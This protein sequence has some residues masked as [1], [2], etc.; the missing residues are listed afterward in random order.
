MSGTQ[1]RSIALIGPAGAGKTSLAEALLHIS[2]A[3]TRQ[4]SVEAGTSVGDASPEARERGSSTEINFMQFEWMGDPFSLIDIPGSPSFADDAAIALNAADLAI[5][6]ID[7]DP[8]RAPLAEP[9]LRKLERAGVPHALFVNKIEQARGSI[10]ELL[11]ALSPMSAAA[12]VAR[13]IPIRSGDRV[14]GFVDLALERAYHY[15]A[16]KPSQQ[17]ALTEELKAD[18]SDARFHM[19]EQLADHDDI[20]LEQLLSDEQPSL[21]TIFADLAQETAS[22][23]IVPV[24]FGSAANGFGIRRLLKMLRHD[25]PSPE[26]TAE[27]LGIDGA[28]AQVLKISHAA[29]VGRL[30]IA[31]L[32]GGK[33]TDGAE[34]QDS[35]GQTLRAGGLFALQG[36]ATAKIASA[37]PGAVLGIAKVDTA[38][39]GDLIGISARPGGS[40]LQADRPAT[41]CAIAIAAKDHKDEVRLSTALNRLAEEDHALHWT[42]DE[43]SRETLL[44]GVSD[45][46]LNVVLARLRRRYGVAVTAQP[47]TIAYRES[48]RK[49][50]TQRGRHKKQSGGHGQF[51]DVVLEVRPLER[52]EGIR[53]EERITGGAIPKQW[54]PAVEKGVQD[55]IAKG[56]LGFPVVDVAAI[57]VDGSFHSVDSSELAFRTAGRIAMSEALAAASPY[58]LEPI[59]HVT[60]MTPGSA[61]SRITSAIA[62]RRGQ[63]LR[64][65]SREGWSAWDVIEVLLPEAGLQGLEAE[66]RSMSQGMASFETHFD[67]LAEV[68]PK[69]ASS[70]VQRVKE[71]A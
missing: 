36:S 64:M 7:P 54:I 14:D 55:A 16:G 28:A 22:G 41:N 46:H 18:E 20:L 32:F 15:E 43:A 27:R 31:R 37:D 12:L 25:T 70:I 21:Q 67:H 30:A 47:P 13:Q 59:A 45:E 24:L 26:R 11:S 19:L 53:F 65:T 61:S 2:G 33:L 58:L 42:Q 51:G 57:L 60:I 23:L 29:T 63:M 3:I 10:Q 4:G 49:P 6:V 68:A 5:V 71:P 1:S 56:P 17:I 69:L 34:L 39:A 40:A 44:H 62:S 66:V 50:V 35:A 38:K 9:V 52:G 48:I 8:A